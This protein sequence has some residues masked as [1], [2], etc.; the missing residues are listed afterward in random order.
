MTTKHIILEANNMYPFAILRK[1][2]RDIEQIQLKKL[3]RIIG[4]VYEKSKF[5]HKFYDENDFHPSMLKS[6]QDIE[7]IPIV[8]RSLLRTTPVE[9]ILT[10]HNLDKLHLHTTSG[11]SGIPVQFYY[12]S[13]EAF[14][15]YLYALRIFLMAGMRFNDITVALRDPVDIKP[16]ALYQRLGILKQDYYN[17]YNPMQ[18]IYD[19]L[20]TKYTKIDILKAQPSDLINLCYIIRHGKRKFPSVRLIFTDSEVLSDFARQYIEE[21][22]DRRIFDYYGSVENGYIA[23]QLNG[24][25]KYFLNEDQVLLENK[26]KLSPVGDAIVTNLRNTTFP[27]IRYQIGDIVEFGDG[28]SDLEGV[29]LKTI[30]RVQGKFLDFIVLPD[31]SIISPHIPKQE[32]T[33]LDGIK[34]FQI[35]QKE[36]DK[37]IVKIERD[38]GYCEQIEQ[39]IINRLNQVFKNQIVCTIEYDDELSTKTTKKFKVI[40]SEVAQNF[41]SGLN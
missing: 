6:Y 21:T 28:Q 41:I 24:S 17:I 1:S 27:I 14:L 10:D 8:K 29:N 5:Y 3:K 19:A 15:T 38:E 7:L 22:L 34:K 9:E 40:N 16:Q 13:K 11:S 25:K 32:L 39:Q 18:D 35:I 37:V 12:N 23:F 4:I 30:D 26:N 31:K 33:H 2:R 36:F 20:C